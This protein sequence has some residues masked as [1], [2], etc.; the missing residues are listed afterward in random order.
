MQQTDSIAISI[1]CVSVLTHNKKYSVYL[2]Y[3]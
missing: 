3:H 1:S 2:R